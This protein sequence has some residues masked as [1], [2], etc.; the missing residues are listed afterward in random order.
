MTKI[1]ILIFTSLL[2]I[3]ACGQRGS[4]YLPEDETAGEASNETSEEE[5]E[6]S[7]D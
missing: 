7:S 2:L 5:Q 6:E 3:S 4:L 1:L